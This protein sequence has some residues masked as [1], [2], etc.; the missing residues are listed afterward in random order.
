M[1]FEDDRTMGVK[2][3]AEEYGC[4]NHRRKYKIMRRL[5][6]NP[7]VMY[8]KL[9]ALLEEAENETPAAKMPKNP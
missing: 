4:I 9:E 2:L 8:W 3:T 6:E 1:M 7:H 5:V